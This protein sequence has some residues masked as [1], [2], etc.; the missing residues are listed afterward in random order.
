MSTK[1]SIS[2]SEEYHL[3]EEAFEEDHVYLE[4]ED[5]LVSMYS[6]TSISVNNG[7]VTTLRIPNHLWEKIVGSWLQWLSARDNKE[8]DSPEGLISIEE[9]MEILN[10]KQN[11]TR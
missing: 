1:A 11:Q 3:Y 8:I 7:D 2:H 5:C 10:E 4:I 9:A 6:K